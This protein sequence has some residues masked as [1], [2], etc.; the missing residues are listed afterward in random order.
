M[1]VS[2][3]NEEKHQ[4]NGITPQ[5]LELEQSEIEEVFSVQDKKPKTF[6]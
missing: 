4:V 1:L 6:N 2:V 3:E 5:L